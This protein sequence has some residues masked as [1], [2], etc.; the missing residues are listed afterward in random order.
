MCVNCKAFLI[1]IDCIYSLIN[2]L[3][4]Y[5]INICGFN[6]AI[7]SNVNLLFNTGNNN[8][9]TLKLMSPLKGLYSK[10]KNSFSHKN[11]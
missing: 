3:N 4:I 6:R 1:L 10:T 8:T 7:K 5:L 2:Q 9:Q 11:I